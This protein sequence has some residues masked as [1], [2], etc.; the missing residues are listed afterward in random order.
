MNDASGWPQSV[1]VLGGSSE[2]ARACVRELVA[3]RCRT[4]VLAGRGPAG[5]GPLL[6]AAHEAKAAGATEVLILEWDATAPASHQRML[7]EAFG[8]RTIDLVLVTV[9]VLADEA[10]SDFDPYAT[11]S[12]LTTNFT[13]PAAASLGA[14][15]YLRDQGQGKLVVLSSVAGE[16]VRRVNFVYGASKAGLDG[17]ARGL[18]ES[19]WGSGVEVM[20]VRPGFVRTRMTE[21][22]AAPP[23]TSTKEQVAAA[24]IRGL[25]QRRQVVWVP[26]AF[27]GVM[28][29]IRHLPSSV[30]RRLPF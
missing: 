20:V 24:V 5:P 25:E 18:G 8:G 16:R 9:G 28:A 19:L 22:R 1:L 23:L 2:I 4:V 29:V 30:V 10:Q 12:V 21:G 11:A 7:D 15:K 26:G 13:G 27:R 6:D 3:R 14:A 17:F